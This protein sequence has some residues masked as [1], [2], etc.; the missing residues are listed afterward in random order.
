[1]PL[2]TLEIARGGHLKPNRLVLYQSLPLILQSLLLFLFTMAAL[3]LELYVGSV[4]VANPDTFNQPLY[5]FL[6]VL[7]RSN[8]WTISSIF[9]PLMFLRGKPSRRRMFLRWIRTDRKEICIKWIGWNEGNTGF[10]NYDELWS[11]CTLY[12]QYIGHK[13][14]FDIC[15]HLWRFCIDAWFVLGPKM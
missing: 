11:V 12:V 15:C 1:M 9:F 2:T 4:F 13:F 14:I 3:T 5:A 7:V 6:R 10:K 8:F